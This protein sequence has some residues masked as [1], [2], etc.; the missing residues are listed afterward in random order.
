MGLYGGILAM[1]GICV[2]AIFIT[3]ILNVA[4]SKGGRDRNDDE[5]DR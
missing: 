3:G 4:I 1:L 5:Y 2:A